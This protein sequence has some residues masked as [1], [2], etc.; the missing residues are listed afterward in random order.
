M[1]APAE[2]GEGMDRRIADQESS[3]LAY[4]AYMIGDDNKVRSATVIEAESDQE[5]ISLSRQLVDG[6]AIELWDRGRFV[7]R[8]DV[9]RS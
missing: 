9:D 5:A 2:S 3:T 6:H 1:L 7:A 8:L 4:R